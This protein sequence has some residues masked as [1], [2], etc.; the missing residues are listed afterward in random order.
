MEVVAE[1]QHE[2]NS[3][4][5]IVNGN[6]TMEGEGGKHSG[7][8]KVKKVRR[9]KRSVSVKEKQSLCL[10]GDEDAAGMS[11]SS[12]SGLDSEG[13][14][15]ICSSDTTDTPGT[16]PSPSA[17]QSAETRV[18]PFPDNVL[19]SHNDVSNSH[20]DVIKSHDDVIHS[21]DD[22]VTNSHDDVIKSHDDVINSNDDVI[23]SY[24]GDVI[25][26]HDDVINSPDISCKFTPASGSHRNNS[27]QREFVT[28]GEAADNEKNNISTPSLLIRNRRAEYLSGAKQGSREPHSA[29]TLRSRDWGRINVDITSLKSVYSKEGCSDDVDGVES[30]SRIPADMP[31]NVKLSAARQAYEQQ[32][33]HSQ[34][35]SNSDFT[36]HSS[37]NGQTNGENSRIHVR[38][39]D[40]SKAI[41][42]FSLNGQEEVGSCRVCSRQ[43]FQMERVKAEGACWHKNCFR[44]VECNRQ[45]SVDTYASHGGQLYCQS[46]HKQLFLPKAVDAEQQD[47]ASSKSDYGLEDLQHLNVRDRFAMFENGAPTSPPGGD[48]QK[49]YQPELTASGSIA[50]KMKKFQRHCAAGDVEADEEGTRLSD[51]DSSVSSDAASDLEEGSEEKVTRSSRKYLR[52]QAASFSGMKDVKSRFEGGMSR[53]EMLREERKG[54]LTRLRDMICGAREHRAA[55]EEALKE[56]NKVKEKKGLDDCPQISQESLKASYQRALEEGSVSVLAGEDSGAP[57]S[58]QLAAS[59]AHKFESGQLDQGEEQTEETRRRRQEEAELFQEANT[60]RDARFMFLQMD[61]QG[62]VQQSL[63]RSPSLSARPTPLKQVESETE[64]VDGD[65]TDEDRQVLL[66][67]HTARLMLDKFKQLET[68]SK[69]GS[70]ASGLTREVASGNA[71]EVLSLFRQ[72]EESAM[73]DDLS[74]GP[75]PLKCMTPPADYTG[76]TG[77]EEEYTY[78]DEDGELDD[79]Q[80]ETDQLNM[81][82]ERARSLRARFE[83]WEKLGEQES[84]CSVEEDCRPSL[85]TAKNLRAM[86]ESLK[87]QPQTVQKPQ[88][89]VS[90]FVAGSVSEMCSSCLQPVY[91]MERLE[92]NQRVLH[93]QCF[94]CSKCNCALRMENYTVNAGSL[95]CSTHFR[96]LFKIK[97][98]YDEGFGLRRR[99]ESQDQRMMRTRVSE[100]TEQMA[101]QTDQTKQTQQTDQ[102]LQ[103]QQTDQIYQTDQTD[104]KYQTDQIQ[105]TDQTIQTQQTDLTRQT[106]QTHQT[107][108]AD[109]TDQTDQTYQT[110]QTAERVCHADTGLVHHME[111]LEK[112][113]TSSRESTGGD[114]CSQTPEEQPPMLHGEFHSE[115]ERAGRLISVSCT[116]RVVAAER[117]SGENNYVPENDVSG[118]EESKNVPIDKTEE[119]VGDDEVLDIS[120]EEESEVITGHFH[121]GAHHEVHDKQSDVS[122]GIVCEERSGE[123]GSTALHEVNDDGS[124]GRVCEERIGEVGRTVQ[125]EVNGDGSVCVVEGGD[126]GYRCRVVSKT[127]L[128]DGLVSESSL[129]VSLSALSGPAIAVEDADRFDDVYLSSAANN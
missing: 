55:Y 20:D 3:T 62:A 44:C 86:F 83:Q 26:S 120:V 98:D 113:D 129:D 14:S 91:A 7:S 13:D 80:D 32:T 48:C 64:C 116:D 24:D 49:H 123:D 96:Q 93:K 77:S 115:D 117:G 27:A 59:L 9:K 33:Q 41:K 42:K 72:M 10:S 87:D 25:N 18:T 84:A 36:P 31:A 35:L 90:R 29:P 47:Q 126:G 67:N 89:K 56:Q 125:N 105:H 73:R 51:A 19:N 100:Q 78:T 11:S 16:S 102:T 108:Q 38:S 76:E 53:R 46:H 54:E 45:L 101:D 127:T 61:T 65:E 40:S 109:Q 106:Y 88:P 22:D 74:D 39:Y 121:Y 94:R 104:Q 2:E 92:I 124:V 95:F 21:H 97:G 71:R 1:K 4:K 68:D 66:K 30:I 17:L 112:E 69:H 111:D 122:G 81:S 82:H 58:R 60:A 8:G 57:V 79:S 128:F 28:S 118:G 52:E 15:P 5:L 63:S 37:A 107:H 119:M 110:D 75:R 23:H 103:T 34:S 43:V 50:N 85:D 12:S 6:K 70:D 99:D 114:V